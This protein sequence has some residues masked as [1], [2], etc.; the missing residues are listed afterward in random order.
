[1]KW[2]WSQLIDLNQIVRFGGAPSFRVELFL[3][4]FSLHKIGLVQ[5]ENGAV[6][7]VRC[8]LW[9]EVAQFSGFLKCQKAIMR[10][11]N[12]MIFKQ[13]KPRPFQQRIVSLASLRKVPVASGNVWPVCM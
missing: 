7:S 8:V 13:K 4:R 12:F 6:L 5:F 9:L 11:I 2:L 10:S 3:C 1:M